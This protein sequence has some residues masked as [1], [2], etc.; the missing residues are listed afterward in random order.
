MMN[1]PD[2]GGNETYKAVWGK[3]VKNKIRPKKGVGKSL[4][5]TQG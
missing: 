1:L 5:V 3:K 2:T 4:N